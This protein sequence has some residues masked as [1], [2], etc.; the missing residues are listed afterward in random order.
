[1]VAIVTRLVFG[2][3]AIAQ[4]ALAR[5]RTREALAAYRAG[6]RVSKRIRLLHPD[7]VPAEVAAAT[8]G[9]LGANLPQCRNLTPEGRAR[10]VVR[11]AAVRRAGGRGVLRPGAVGRRAASR[12]EVAR[13]DRRGAERREEHKEYYRTVCRRCVLLRRSRTREAT[14]SEARRSLSV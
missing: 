6:R 13:A 1:M 11:S 5:S 2:T 9:K 14:G 8:S 4:A 10:G 7:G 3:M 12:G